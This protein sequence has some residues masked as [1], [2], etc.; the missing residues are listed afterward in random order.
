MDN[1]FGV[2]D[3]WAFDILTT[4]ACVKKKKWMGFRLWREH[5]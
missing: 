2:F 4:E 5:L 1:D 3:E